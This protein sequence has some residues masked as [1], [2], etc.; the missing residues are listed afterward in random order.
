VRITGSG[1]VNASGISSKVDAY[2]SGSGDI[3][4][5]G[6]TES[7]NASVVGLVELMRVSCRRQRGYSHQRERQ[8]HG[9][10]RESFNNAQSK[11]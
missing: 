11:R 5:S 2:I 8:R 4:I 3:N 10:A 9:R 7:L 6:S 1:N